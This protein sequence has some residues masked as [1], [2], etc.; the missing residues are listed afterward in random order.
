MNA[1]IQRHHDLLK[2][3]ACLLAGLLIGVT[4]TLEY[5][6]MVRVSNHPSTVNVAPVMPTPTYGYAPKVKVTLKLVQSWCINGDGTANPCDTNHFKQI[7][8]GVVLYTAPETSHEYFGIHEGQTGVIIA[9]LY[10]G[11]GFK[12]FPYWDITSP[13]IALWSGQTILF[14]DYIQLDQQGRIVSPE[15]PEGTQP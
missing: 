5:P 10:R 13:P 12:G 8:E 7:A 11:G 6:L 4:V 3:I 14:T 1:F 2:T 15:L 9:R